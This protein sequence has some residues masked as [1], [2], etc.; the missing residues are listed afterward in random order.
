MTDQDPA[1]PEIVT[2]IKQCQGK[3]TLAA[4]RLGIAP[5]EIR[6]LA[7][8]HPE[9]KAAIEEALGRFKETTE[10]AFER[11]VVNGEP[12]AV[13]EAIKRMEKSELNTP[14][15]PPVRP[16]EGD[17][18]Q[19]Q[20]AML[21]EWA[22][23]RLDTNDIRKRALASDPPFLPSYLQIKNARKTARVNFIKYRQELVAEATKTGYR[24][25]EV[26]IGRLAAALELLERDLFGGRHWVCDVKMVGDEVV[27]IERFNEGLVKQF[28]GLLDDI[29]RE[30]GGRASRLDVNVDVT[31][32]SD[33]ELRRIVEGAG[34]SGTGTAQTREGEA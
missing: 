3:V 11:A 30:V 25:A 34:A 14:T 32:L 4:Q 31:K 24:E 21:V 10:L 20:R 23:A 13:R 22:A 5:G 6:A 8:A 28:R 12:W 19:T 26:R 33:E 27:E 9:I 1:I 29:A 16:R 15:T 7:E 17:I 2:A 18:N